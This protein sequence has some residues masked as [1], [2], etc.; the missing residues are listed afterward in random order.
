MSPVIER[1]GT[2]FFGWVLMLIGALVL[3]DNTTPLFREWGLDFWEIFWPLLLII[4]GARMIVR[5]SFRFNVQVEARRQG[6]FGSRASSEPAPSG[7]IIVDAPAV[8]VG[9]ITSDAVSESHVAGEIDLEITS[10]NFRGGNLS[11]VFGEINARMT[12]CRVAEGEHGFGLSAVFGEVTLI[13]PAG[14][15]FALDATTVFGEVRV[16]QEKRGGIF[17]S[18]NYRTPGYATADRRLRISVSTVFGEVKIISA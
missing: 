16:M 2:P 14:M 10:Q 11:T 7:T 4:I 12:R 18:V 17:S 6:S 3:I 9:S 8:I 15:E 5:R 1:R 13:V